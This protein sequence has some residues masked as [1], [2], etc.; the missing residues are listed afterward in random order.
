MT[1]YLGK[2][3]LILRS[4]T[5]PDVLINDPNPWYIPTETRDYLLKEYNHTCAVCGRKNGPFH[6]DHILSVARGGTASYHNLQ[7]LCRTCNLQ[8]SYHALD[9]RSYEMGYV[10]PLIIERER[11]IIETIQNIIDDPRY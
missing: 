7:V 4:K 10:I 2:H 3:H 9:P 8:K 5:E 1:L 6:I 11:K